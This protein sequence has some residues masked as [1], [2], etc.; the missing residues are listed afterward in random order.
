LLVL[1]HTA[2][3]D[4]RR[5]QALALS[6]SG[7]AVLVVG[8]V[9]NFQ[10]TYGPALVMLLIGGVLSW[11][12]VGL[13]DR[14]VSLPRAD[15]ALADGLRERTG[16]VHRLYNWVLP[17]DHV[18]SGPWGLTVFAIYNQDGPVSIQG[19]K[20]RD[21]RPLWQRL[22]RFGRRPLRHPGALLALDT[23]A[24][25]E[26]LVAADPALAAVPIDGIAVFTSPAVSLQ[27]DQADLT[28]LRAA[29]LGEWVRGA[30]KRPR[31]TPALQERLDTVLGEIAAG[32][33]QGKTEV[34]A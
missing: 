32:R 20:W 21:R 8:L 23:A 5:R 29:E 6:L 9:L 30:N 3:A 28:V 19:A 15:R 26:A 16:R 31:L 10:A 18:L 1:T 2:L 4:R 11:L 25:R 34:P 22:F 7:T 12:G 13:S 17:A 33:L 14:W 27:I 24:L